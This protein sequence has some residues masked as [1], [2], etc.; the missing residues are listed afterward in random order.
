MEEDSD[1]KM[2]SSILCADFL[3]E[4]GLI[5]SFSNKRKIKKDQRLLARPALKFV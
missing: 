2:L 5:A 3:T 4:L 1:S